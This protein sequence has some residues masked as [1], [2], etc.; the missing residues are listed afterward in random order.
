MNLQLLQFSPHSLYC[1]Y[2]IRDY[3]P[4]DEMLNLDETIRELTEEDSMDRKTNVKANMTSYTALQNNSKCGFFFQK[5]AHSIDAIIRLRGRN[6]IDEFTY[7]FIDSW[8]MRHKKD[9]HTVEHS[10]IPRF[11]SGAYYTYVPEPQPFIEFCEFNEKIKLKTNMLLLFPGSMLHK[12]SENQSE[13]DR[14]SM[15]FNINMEKQV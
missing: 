5:V 9:D 8:G 10:H 15:A 3:L 14:I 2:V 1:A 11:W 13:E 6:V 4:K 12:V 7:N